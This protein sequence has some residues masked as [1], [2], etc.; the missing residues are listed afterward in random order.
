MT[1]IGEYIDRAYIK[2]ATDEIKR[3]LEWWSRAPICRIRV[4]ERIVVWYYENKITRVVK[5][6][7]K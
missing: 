2:K 7:C 5:K 1:T 4:V 3:R 6:A